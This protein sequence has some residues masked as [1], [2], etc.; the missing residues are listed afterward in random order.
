VLLPIALP[1][2]KTSAVSDL[3]RNLQQY[4]QSLGF[5]QLELKLAIAWNVEIF[6]R[7]PN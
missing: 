6:G 3:T 5:D 7:L 2:T 1:P 4:L